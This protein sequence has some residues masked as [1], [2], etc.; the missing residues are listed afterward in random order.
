M[1]ASIKFQQ[2]PS[3]QVVP[4]YLQQPSEL[5]LELL[6][7]EERLELELELELREL[8]LLELDD[9]LELLELE[10]LELDDRLELLELLELDDRLELLERLEL[11]LELG[12]EHS[13]FVYGV[14]PSLQVQQRVSQLVFV[15]YDGGVAFA[16]GAPAYFQ[17]NPDAV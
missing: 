17:H 13:A 4:T 16:S 5:E 15:A 7:L 11:L 14:C 3:G 6:E 10:L 12:H 9:R 2:I 1:H 8:E